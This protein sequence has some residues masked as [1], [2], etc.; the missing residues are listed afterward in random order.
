MSISSVTMKLHFCRTCNTS[1]HDLQNLKKVKSKIYVDCYN[2]WRP[3]LIKSLQRSLSC[4]II[5]L[6]CF[7]ANFGKIG[8]STFSW[9]ETMSLSTM[10]THHCIASLTRCMQGFERGPEWPLFLTKGQLTVPDTNHLD[11]YHFAFFDRVLFLKT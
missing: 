9:E 4:Q 1:N 3:H 8:R 7:K 5:I 11:F 6:A 10:F 2:D